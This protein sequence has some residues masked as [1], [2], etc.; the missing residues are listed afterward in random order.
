[1]ESA[2]AGRPAIGAATT[3]FAVLSVLIEIATDAGA[4]SGTDAGTGTDA[5]AFFH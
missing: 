3:T 5:E 2:D 4:F 1:M